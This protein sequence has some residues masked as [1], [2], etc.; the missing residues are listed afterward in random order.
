MSIVAIKIN[1]KQA[2]LKNINFHI[3][4]EIQFLR[5]IQGKIDRNVIILKLH[6]NAYY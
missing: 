5:N 6:V 2:R 1:N 3:I 4:R